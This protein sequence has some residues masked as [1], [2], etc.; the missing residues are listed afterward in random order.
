MTTH[1]NDDKIDSY[2]IKTVF[3]L[4][5]LSLNGFITENSSAYLYYIHN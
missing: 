1:N 4:S 2:G 3:K 5:Q